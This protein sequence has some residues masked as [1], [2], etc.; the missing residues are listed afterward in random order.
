MEVG[1][2]VIMPH[3]PELGIGQVVKSSQQYI[4]VYF[5][6]VDENRE[7]LA[8]KNALVRTEKLSEKHDVN[9]NGSK[10]TVK[11]IQDGKTPLESRVKRD[12]ENALNASEAARVTL[13]QFRP[14]S[15]SP[16]IL[17]STSNAKEKELQAKRQQADL[18]AIRN[19]PFHAMAEVEAETLNNG[20][21][22]TLKQ[23]LYAHEETRT[24]NPLLHNGDR[25]NVMSWTHPAIQIALTRELRETVDIKA[26]GYTLRAITPLVR[27]KF[28][29]VLP[30]ISGL[31]EPGGMVGAKKAEKHATGLKAVK[32]QMTKDQVDAF[33]SKMNGMMLVTGAPGSGKT[34]V[35]MQRIRFLFDQQDERI[36]HDQNVRY[37][38]NLTKIFLANDN[39]ITY[40]KD[41][42]ENGLQIPS[43]V[44]EPV[45]DFINSYLNDVWDYKHGATLR[46]KKLF[47]LEERARMAFFGLCNEQDLRRLWQTYESQI[48]ARLAEADEAQWIYF[49]ET[50]QKCTAAEQLASSLN[51]MNSIPPN[52][53]PLSSKFSMDA[54][55]RRIHKE[56]E[57]TR[58]S[59]Q[60]G[61]FLEIFDSAFYRWLY[62]VY[63]PFDSL[64]SYFSE[65]M[66][67]GKVRIKKGMSSRIDESEILEAIRDDW[68]KRTYG[69]EEIPWLAFLLRFA[70]PAETDQRSRFR[71]IPNPL[72]VTGMLDGARWTHVMVDEA[73]DLCVA[74]A[75]L[76]GSLVHPDGAFTVSADFNQVVSPVWGMETPEAF[77]IGISL[78]D[79]GV[80]QSFPF[81]KNMRQSKQIGLFLQSFYQSVFGKIAPFEVNDQVEGP[82]PLLFIGNSSDFAPRIHQRLNVLRRNQSIQSFA[83]LQVNE[84]EAAMEQIR[85]S[86]EKRGI[87]LAP[88]WA[89]SDSSGR[90]VTT[91]VER[92]KGLEY[93]ACFVI[94][95]D[96][97][98]NRNLNYAKNR[99]Y[100]ALSRPTLHMAML[101]NEVPRALQRVNQGLM[102][103]V[104]I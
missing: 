34:T 87:E 47:H 48:A 79:K 68:K 50:T 26:R 56:Y 91:S 36:S 59:M 62:W 16:S 27:A 25:I 72:A 11:C 65:H 55:Y 73:Q 29:Q 104:R 14:Y 6:S 13:E 54:L 22:Q 35:A 20:K 58:I 81:A 15:D 86:L 2:S 10:N 32:L 80:Y 77:K 83:L 49:P 33:L 94:G 21:T 44:V 53:E 23:L 24:N 43:S 46:R 45:N 96:D 71:E 40:S 75:A 102:D 82:K 84:D 85:T 18:L 100:V 7:Y 69:K 74:Q 70:L 5:P 66:Y 57:A 30:V 19:N 1:W 89:A 103:V 60:N 39:L 4:T 61:G 76:L 78:R 64:I 12:Q 51:A 31:Y 67:D 8:S 88:I 28:S 17:G 90:L 42:L 52:G 41:L 99:A 101:C 98:E 9:A 93:D 3:A 95:L 97:D 63:N 37:S 38:E 92:I